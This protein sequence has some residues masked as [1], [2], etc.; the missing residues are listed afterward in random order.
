MCCKENFPEDTATC[1]AFARSPFLPSSR[2]SAS[3]LQPSSN[4]GFEHP[5]ASFWALPSSQD[6]RKPPP[7]CSTGC[8]GAELLLIA[9]AKRGRQL[10][11]VFFCFSAP[12]QAT[13]Q[14]AG[15]GGGQ[16]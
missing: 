12:L 15:C 1:R 3:G 7:R 9:S 6:P 4:C 11:G 13:L 16:T 2:A 14:D 10:L 8:R 5:K